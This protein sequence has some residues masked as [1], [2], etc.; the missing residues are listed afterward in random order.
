MIWFQKCD[1]G[2]WTLWVVEEELAG[3][4]ILPARMR[5]LLKNPDFSD[6]V[7]QRLFPQAYPDDP[8]AEAEYQRLLRADLVQR[9]LAAG[10]TVEQTLSRARV[11]KLP[12]GP[13]ILEISLSGEDL[14]V[15]L[16]FLHDTRLTIGTALDITD[17][18]WEHELDPHHPDFEEMLLLNQLSYLE[19]T[20]L[21]AIRE[22]EDLG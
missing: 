22:A 16:G 11:H 7:V 8:Y 6:R 21:Q 19:E 17:E 5:S 14:A 4:R 1:D 20:L 9:K 12:I 2:G 10:I 18:G 13:T 3:I 15:W